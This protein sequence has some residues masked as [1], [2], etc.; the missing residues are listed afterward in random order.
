MVFTLG[1]AKHAPGRRAGGV[2]GPAGSA[3]LALQVIRVE[4]DADRFGDLLV[5]LLAGDQAEM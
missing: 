2:G 5:T 4:E 1:R 3:A